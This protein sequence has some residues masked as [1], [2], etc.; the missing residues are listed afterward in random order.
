MQTVMGERKA[1]TKKMETRYRRATRV[2]K[3]TPWTIGALK[4]WHRDQPGLQLRSPRWT[5]R[6]LQ[7]SSLPWDVKAMADTEIQRLPGSDRS[8]RGSPLRRSKQ[9][10]LS[11]D[12]IDAIGVA[13][14]RP[15]ESM[16]VSRPLTSVE[17]AGRLSYA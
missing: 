2:E 14:R 3:F 13:V 11:S 12:Q 15:L 1:V 7:A 16:T 9:S 10:A 5:L 4:G 17:A 8:G 6:G